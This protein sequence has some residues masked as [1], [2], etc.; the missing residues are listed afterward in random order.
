VRD[1]SD[2]LCDPDGRGVH[3]CGRKHNNALWGKPVNRFQEL[4]FRAGNQHLAATHFKRLAQAGGRRVILR[5]YNS[6][7]QHAVFQWLCCA[8][9]ET[10][11]FYIFILGP[12]TKKRSRVANPAFQNFLRGCNC[13]A[14]LSQTVSLFFLFFITQLIS[15]QSVFFS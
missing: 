5:E 13:S 14:W 9:P 2:V 7:L 1:A 11:I 10:G 4:R 3:G 6:F 15:P 8:K 12:L